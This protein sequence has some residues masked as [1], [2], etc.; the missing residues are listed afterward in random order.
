MEEN[1]AFETKIQKFPT[2]G[3]GFAG[4]PQK[5]CQVSFASLGCLAHEQN[6]SS[7]LA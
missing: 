2:A 6:I 3:P 7:Q 5:A 4:K 1:T